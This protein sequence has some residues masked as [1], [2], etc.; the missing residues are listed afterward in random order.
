[1]KQ[2]L[3]IISFNIPYPLTDG[4]AIAQY[5]FLEKL[6][7]KFDVFF[8]TEVKSEEDEKALSELKRSL[9]RIHI[10]EYKN[11]PAKEGVVKSAIKSVLQ[12]ISSIKNRK[13]NQT[14]K[15]DDFRDDAYFQPPLQVFSKAFVKYLH[16]IILKEKIALVQLE[17]YETISLL[18]ALPKHVKKIFVH[19]EIRTK[20]FILSSAESDAPAEYKEYI[21]KCNELVEYNLLKHADKIVVFNENDK[22]LLL[23]YNKNVCL[24]PFGIPQ[25]LITRS[26]PSTFFNRFIFIGGEYHNPNFKGLQWFLNEVYIPNYDSIEWPIYIIGK[27]SEAFRNLYSKYPKIIFEGL[28][29]D[30]DIYYENSVLLSSVFSGSGLRT[31]ILHAFANKVPVISTSFACE[32]LFEEEAD[33]EH[34]CI[35]DG[36]AAF[37]PIYRSFISSPHRSKRLAL[38]GFEYYNDRFSESS[39]LKERLNIFAD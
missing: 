27:W 38:N 3:L 17:F 20:R 8:C 11:Y 5:Y 12:F 32:G 6:C 24:S 37:M 21:I 34:I 2:K 10:L 7:E 13:T 23:K 31:K 30:L 18:L 35:F 33:N 22:N 29:P 26:S 36:V 19:H 4:G 1:M 15:R 16:D 39:L 28:V 25:K 14:P 9:K